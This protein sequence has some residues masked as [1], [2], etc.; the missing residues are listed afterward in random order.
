MLKQEDEKG[1]EPFF[2]GC[3]FVFCE[4]SSGFWMILVC[5]TECLVNS[6]EVT[7]PFRGDLDIVLKMHQRFFS[8]Q[9]NLMLYTPSHKK[10]SWTTPF[11][12]H[13][14]GLGDVVSFLTL[15]Y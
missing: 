1:L 12:K 11:E 7:P 15:L 13:K 3:F 6:L 5:W 14:N 10:T 4:G 9:S 8:L 2:D